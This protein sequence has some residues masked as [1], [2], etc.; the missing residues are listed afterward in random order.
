[1]RKGEKDTA[2]ASH[3]RTSSGSSQNSA[4]LMNLKEIKELIDLIIEKGITDFE[5]ER[6]G[7]RIKISRKAGASSSEVLL[8]AA[9]SHLPAPH[10]VS[11]P[12]ASEAL[13]E[14]AQGKTSPP[15]DLY[16]VRSPMVGTFYSAPGP[17][18][19]HFVRVGDLVRAGQPLCVI[20]A[21]KLMNEIEAEVAGEVVKCYAENGQPVEYGEPLFDL[22]PS[23]APKQS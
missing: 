13:A 1:M 5:L 16:V 14:G 6:S 17:G 8:P 9:E 7:V 10:S 20:E 12:V 2:V 11:R 4:A 3:D 22:R 23:T 21:M 19:E 15:E 18:A